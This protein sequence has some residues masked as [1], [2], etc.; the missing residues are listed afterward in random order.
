MKPPRAL[1]PRSA[2]E[3]IGAALEFHGISDEVR[4][5]RVLA[6]W[7][8]LVGAKIAA[9]TRPYGVD[10]A[11]PPVAAAAGGGRAPAGGARVLWIEV[12]SSAWMHE[13]NLLRPQ[14]LAG[15]LERVGEPRLFDDLRFRLAGRNRREA[16]P[17]RPRARPAAPPRPAPIPATGVAREQI[18]R[19][20]E[21]IDDAELRE[22]V[23]R[24]RI[25]NDR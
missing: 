8:D 1:A 15:L 6:E 16:A 20:V 5:Q 11:A 23:A 9:R 25:A 3:A 4:A 14:I 18:V 22:L 19:E 17:P 12:A 2:R 24:V 13:L 21:R 10:R 7:A